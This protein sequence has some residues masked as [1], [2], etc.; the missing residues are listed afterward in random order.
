[1][2][3]SKTGVIQAVF[4]FYACF[5]HLFLATKAIARIEVST[6]AFALSMERKHIK[7]SLT[8]KKIPVLSLLLSSLLF[9]GSLYADTPITILDTK[10]KTSAKQS[11]N[12]LTQIIKQQFDL[13]QFRE[14]KLQLIVNRQHQPD[15]L[16][17]YLLAKEMHV[18]EMARVDIDRGFHAL[19][20][21]RQYAVETN[22][23]LEQP[24]INANEAACPDTD[25]EFVAFAP[26]DMDIEQDTTIGVAKLAEAHKLKTVRLL[27]GDATR[28]NYMNYMKCPKLVG[29]FYDGDANPTVITT[30]DGLIAY[31]D[32][33]AELKF[34]YKTTNI[35][36][37]C[38]AYKDPMKSVMLADA[39]SQKYA[40]GINNLRVGPSDKAAA[41]AMK[42][43][44]RGRA[45]TAAFK[46][47]YDKF[48]VSS[49]KWGW[50]GEG[51][52]FFGL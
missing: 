26:N 37:A 4:G 50:D 17:V 24:G 20:T 16:L 28:T 39:A 3:Y 8:V 44:I 30:V 31:S 36:L 10:T 33:K 51:S 52:D 11:I 34:N 18:V 9:S 13:S 49:D 47:C 25:V 7:W 43:A 42:A 32:I 38:Q 22:D 27:V 23:V 46:R 21:V 1:M 12:M 29:N 35:W 45:M 2:K 41:C 48:D 40:A 15:H 19:R 14:I 5:H 6:I